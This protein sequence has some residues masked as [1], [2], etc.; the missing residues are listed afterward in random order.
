MRSPGRQQDRCHVILAAKSNKMG[1]NSH[2]FELSRTL[3]CANVTKKN[4]HKEAQKTHNMIQLK[5][6][7]FTGRF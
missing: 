1:G 4:S 7:M 2:G 6:P 3:S 5:R